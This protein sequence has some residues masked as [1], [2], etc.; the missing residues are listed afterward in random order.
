[1]EVKFSTNRK[2]GKGAKCIYGTE[3]IEKFG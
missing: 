2:V 1:M 3:L